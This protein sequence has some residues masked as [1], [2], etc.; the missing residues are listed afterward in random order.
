MESN[1]QKL[2]EEMLH[3]LDREL[4]A[5]LRAGEGVRD[6]F[7][8]M[9]H[10]QMGWVDEGF[11]P[12]QEKGGKKIR[13]LLCLLTCGAAGGSWKAAIPAAAAVEIF[14]NFSLIHDDIEDLSEIRRG[15]PTH[16]K[17]WGTGPAIN[18]GDAMFGSAFLALAGLPGSGEPGILSEVLPRFSRASVEL[19][20]GQHLDMEFENRMD[21]AVEEYLGMISGKTAAVMSLCCEAGALVAG[22]GGETVSGF[23]S[24]GRDL[25]MAFQIHDDILG[26]WGDEANTGKSAESDVITRKKTLPVIYGLSRSGVMRELYSKPG[27]AGDFL[28]RVMAELDFIGAHGFA[29]DVEKKYSEAAQK[30]LEALR[31]SCARN[32]FFS[33]LGE[34]MNTLLSRKR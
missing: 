27:A 9:M 2:S 29:A 4:R 22:A 14:H 13:P 11:A 28:P 16:W 15:R 5:V 6:T 10:Y 34:L 18:T 24:F 19:T 3:A 25:G 31:T 26:I 32:E 30:S 7:Y 17:R 8:L 12:V 23:A 1:L 20:R 21:V 33:A